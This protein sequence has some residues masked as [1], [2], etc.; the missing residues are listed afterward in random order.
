MSISQAGLILD[1]VA[2]GILGFESWLKLRSIHEDSIVV[3]YGQIGCFWRV[4]FLLAWPLL[5]L[6]FVFQFVGSQ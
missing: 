4:L 6:G 1:I 2:A 3:G 5:L